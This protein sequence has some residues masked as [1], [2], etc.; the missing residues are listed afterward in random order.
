MGMN[1]LTSFHFKRIF[2][3][4]KRY[5]P[6]SLDTSIKLPWQLQVNLCNSKQKNVML[7]RF[8]RRYIA[9]ASM[10]I[11]FYKQHK[12]LERYV[13][14]YIKMV[15]NAFLPT[16]WRECWF[17]VFETKNIEFLS[18]NSCFTFISLAETR[19]IWIIHTSSSVP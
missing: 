10:A 17:Y 2:L 5:Y 13:K 6:L 1:R 11:I 15:Q 4:F 12:C 8:C 7:R 19:K 3:N 14:V 16:F 9:I 18:K